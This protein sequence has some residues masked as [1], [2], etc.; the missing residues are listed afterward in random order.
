MSTTILRLTMLSRNNQAAKVE[1]FADRNALI[2]TIHETWNNMPTTT[3]P[4]IKEDK[5]MQNI[6]GKDAQIGKI[7][8]VELHHRSTHL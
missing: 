2:G 1:Y 7:E 6:D 8:R 3:R 5:V 4:F